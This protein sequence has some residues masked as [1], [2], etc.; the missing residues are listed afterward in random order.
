MCAVDGVCRAKKKD[1]MR[2]IQPGLAKHNDGK[3]V[4]RLNGTFSFAATHTDM[5]FDLWW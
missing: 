5:H 4:D 1:A 2:V 3:D